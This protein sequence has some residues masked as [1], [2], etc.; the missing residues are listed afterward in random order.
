[1]S[2]LEKL[3]WRYA[4]KKFDPAKKIRADKL[5]QV[6]DMVKLAPSSMGLQ[7]YRILVIED[8]EIRTQLRQAAFGQAQI[9]DA[10]QVIVFAAE[11]RIDADYVQEYV[12]EIVKTRGVTHESVEA[13]KQTMLGAV[14]SKSEEDKLVWAQKQAYIALGVLVAATADLDIDICPME[15]FNA[16]QF[17]EILSLKEKGLTSAVVA[18]IGYRAA[19]DMFSTFAKVR[20]PD[21]KLFIHV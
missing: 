2:L 11:T 9:T 5:K 12:N 8:P 3:S 13:Y 10:S 7:H 1:M 17:D 18:A 19:D 6:L 4:T 15:G 14:N 20:K 21:D 16:V